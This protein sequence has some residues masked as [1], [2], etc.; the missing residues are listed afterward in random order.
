MNRFFS[1]V[2]YRQS[3]KISENRIPLTPNTQTEALL[4]W[5]QRPDGDRTAHELVFRAAQNEKQPTGLQL[6]FEEQDWQTDNY[7]FAPAAL[8]RGNRFDCLAKP[9]PPMLTKEEAETYAGAPVLSDVP[10]LPKGGGTV[11]LAVGDLATPCVGYFSKKKQQ[12]FLLFFEQK[13]E[14]GNFGISLTEDSKRH[15]LTITLASPCVREEHTYGMC[16]TALPSTDRGAVLKRGDT[17]TFRFWEIRFPCGSITD[18]LN[19]FFACR[20]EIPLPRTH[21]HTVPWSYGW[22]LMEEKYNQRN[23]VAPE[24]FYKSSEA[25]SS[26][27]RQ[28]Q[29]GWVGGAMNTLPA[30]ALGN[31]ESVEKS[32]K[33]LDF[34]FRELQH[35]SGFLYGVFCDGVVYGDGFL[36]PENKN[37]VMSRKNADALYFLVRQLMVLKEKNEPIDPLWLSGVRKLADAF[38]AFW[39]KNGELGQFLDLEKQCPYIAGSASAGIAPAALALCSVFFENPNDLTAAKALAWRY[40]TDY[41]QKGYSNGGPGEILS[42]PD[43]ESAFALLESYVVLYTHTGDDKWLRCA[44]DAASLCASWCV[45]YDYQYDKNTQFYRRGIA[46]TGAVW[47]NVQNKHAAPGICTLSGAS[48]F[49]LYRATGDVRYLALCRDIG[50]AIPQFISRPDQPYYASYI[51]HDG[52]AGWKKRRMALAAKLSLLFTKTLRLPLP[53]RFNPIGRINERVNLSD[54]EGKSNVG[55]VPLGSCWCE[56]SAMLTYLELPAVYV[57]T[58]TAFCFALDHVACRAEQTDAHTLTLHLHNPTK[59]DA[60]YRIFAESGEEQKMPLPDT[61]FLRYQTVFV[62]AGTEKTIS[63]ERGTPHV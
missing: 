11:Q 45:S 61:F 51:W 17:A 13:N 19:R 38:I 57:Q 48:L 10:R 63:I 36:H 42:A 41:I 5:T 31:R 29:T 27:Y 16:S 46:T 39:Q 59:Y 22:Q 14:L 9:Y 60:Q 2:R 54:W 4:R 28:W 44:V 18:F 20:A 55:E 21:P 50:H 15:T 8:Y 6:V 40:Y 56:V 33:T 58:D 49:Q 1:I 30:L 26:I 25:E 35:P 37:I 23:W 62:K 47:A 34:I 24:G 52:S 32:R 12:G 7:I 43:S 53:E 3:I